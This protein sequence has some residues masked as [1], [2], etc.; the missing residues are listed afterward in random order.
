MKRTNLFF[1]LLLLP[2]FLWAQPPEAFNYQAAIRSDNGQAI[3]DQPVNLQISIL[4]GDKNFTTVYTEIHEAHT[5]A[6]GLVNLFIGRG[7][8]TTGDFATIDWG[9]HPHYLQLAIDTNGGF[10]FIEMGASELLSV[11]YA[12]YAGFA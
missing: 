7:D 9:S 2:F 3:V 6:Y 5:N 1:V 8:N 12:L 10:D 4:Q 11:P